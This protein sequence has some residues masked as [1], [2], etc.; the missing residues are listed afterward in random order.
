M[1]T[2]PNHQIVQTIY[3]SP[4]SVVYRGTR[5]EDNQ[6]VVIKVLKNEY[7]SPTD[8]VRYQQEYEITHHLD[9]PG[10]I[11][12]YCLEKYQNT[13]VLILEDFGGE[14][15]KQWMTLSPTELRGG[16][17]T[18]FRQGR[19]ADISAFLSLAIQMAE[20]IGEI[21]AAHLIHKDINPSNWVWNP[22]T[23][24]LKLID[25][26]ISTRLSRENPFLKNPERLEGTLAYMSPEQTGRMNRVLDY[27]TDFYSL[28]VSFYEMLTGGLPFSASDSL[29]LVHSHLAK[30]PQSIREI[31]PIVPPI[32]DELVIKLMA[33]NADDRYQS[34]FGLRNDL[35]NCLA[36]QELETLHFQLGD[37][38]FSGRFQLPQ[39]LYGR[40][41]EIEK[42]LAAFERSSEGATEMM[43]VAG[44]SG[45]GKSALVYEVHKPMTEKNGYFASGKFDQLQRNVPYSALSQAF[46]EFC[47]YL[48]SEPSTDRLNQ[49]R[50]TIL[51]AVGNNGQ[52][53]IDL[54]PALEL[55]IGPQP[56]VP[57]LG[58]TEAQNRF[59]WVF[60][61]FVRAISQKEHPLVIFIDDWQWADSASLT[62]LKVLMTHSDIHYFLLIGAYRDNEVDASHPLSMTLEDLGQQSTAV[63]NTLTLDNLSI[64]QVNALIADALHGPTT[65]VQPLTEL[66]YE[67]TFGNAFFTTEFLKALSD[68]GLLVFDFDSFRWQW[69]LDQIRQKEMTN[70]VVE[71]MVGKIQQ[72]PPTTQTVLKRAACIGNQFELA[73][74]SVIHKQSVQFTIDA[75]LEA[76]VEGLIIPLDDHYKIV[77]SQEQNDSSLSAG[78]SHFKFQHDRIQQAAY[79]LIPESEKPAL[80]LEI[81]RLLLA[82]RSEEHLDDKIFDIVNHL[83]GGQALMTDDAER[84][85]LASLNLRAGKKAKEGTAYQAALN[86]LALG[87]PLLGGTAWKKS[88]SLAFELHKEQGECEFLSGHFARSDQLLAIALDN[89]QSQ[90]DRTQV[91]VIK[92]ALLAGQGKYREAVAMAIEALNRFGLSVPSLE[93]TEAQQQATET[94]M[95]H[96]QELM[97][98]RAIDDLWHL[99]LMQDDEMKACTQIIAM[100]IDSIAI[101]GFSDLLAFYT[102]KMVNLSIQYGL[103][104]FTPVG[105]TFFATILSGGFKDYSRAY[106]FSALALRLNQEKLINQTVSSKIYNMYAFLSPLQEHFN[107]SAKYFRETYRIAIENGDFAYAGYAMAEIPRYILPIS[108]DEGTKTTQ[109]SIVYCQKSNN[110]PM[111]S[112]NQMYEGFINN[113]Q[114]NNSEQ[115]SF[116]HGHFTEEAFI[117]AFETTAPV[118]LAL[119]KRYK[120]QSLCLFGYYERALLLVH[121][122]ATWIAAFG[123][124]DLSLRSDYFLYAGITVAAL[125]RKASEE[126]EKQG[127]LEILDECIA[128]NQLLSEQCSINFEHAYLILEAEKAA[129][130]NRILDATHFYDQAIAVARQNDYRCNEGLASELA[131]QFWLT[132]QKEDF[133]AFYLKSAHYAYTLWGATGKIRDLEER[134]SMPNQSSGAAPKNA[135]ETVMTSSIRSSDGTS[136]FPTFNLDFA[137]V[138]KASQVIAGE[139]ELT[140]L[141]TRL[142]TIIIENAGAQR[143]VF[144]IQKNEQWFIEAEGV[145]EN[146]EVTVLQ[147]IPID[148]SEPAEKQPV[149]IGFLNYVIRTKESLV[150]Y[151]A[152]QEKMSSDPYLVGNHMKSA[153]C[154]PLINQGQLVGILYLENKLVEGVFTPARLEI[155]NVL[156]SQTAIS[157]ENALLYRTLEQKVE[158]RTAQLAEANQE[159]TALNEQLKSENL[160]MSAE[161]DVSRQ[162]QRML[163]PKEDELLQI[164]DLEIAGFMEPTDEVGGDYYDVLNYQGRILMGIGDVTGHGL[165]SGALAIMVQT[166]V[167]TLLANNETDPIKFLLTLN[168]AIYANSQRMESDKNMTLVLLDYKE[169]QLN[170]VGQHEEVIVVRKNSHQVELIETANLGFPIGLVE[171]LPIAQT[172]QLTL[173]SGDVV[174][175]YTD[176]ITEASNMDNVE[177]RLERLCDIAK[178][179]SHQS[180]PEICQAIIDDLQQFVGTKK[181]DDDVTLLVLK[182]K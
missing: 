76:V 118:F 56:E 60:Q 90:F 121:E 88:Y 174:V 105:Y 154:H 81:G 149:P 128:E 66:V 134:Y 46:N 96:Y 161:L 83:N 163:L 127:Y 28:G 142:M 157:L 164:D 120:L 144:L 98:N 79:A 82:S 150:L 42:L 23:N 40:E 146:K 165:E 71:L 35:E 103:S 78:Q 77:H 69:S 20:V 99:P 39:K 130:E 153:L 16:A 158:E 126:T 27:R 31:N 65:S 152:K 9:L 75:L 151:D 63:I 48:L 167:R 131:V 15:L 140:Q 53:L 94:E 173:N 50:K 13:R 123:G 138:V 73:T 26:S 145:I 49:W 32:V 54:I 115:T 159:I 22:L 47:H 68:E 143:G 89:A 87:L 86:Y 19:V 169:G 181:I 8:L 29:E 11:K 106:Q 4:H 129:L 41:P 59:H 62:L 179:N 80:H 6:P 10:V 95:A 171:E 117:E 17:K 25:F 107:T 45:V 21:H 51:A 34:A 177:Y 116:D 156:L 92:L 147:S 72:F 52:V 85:R 175:L 109:E 1:I 97:A 58:P 18:L 139:I 36:A 30:P 141:L 176:G 137:S 124:I 135:T 70:N 14:S 160:R 166:A 113:L 100:A 33:K 57:K 111:L 148:P 110:V 91:Y 12:A 178:L 43:W 37:K 44:Y 170:L 38:D 132:H 101:G 67:K 155:L 7:P 180:A 122:R 2:I 84:V 182:K 3:E 136:I 61:N 119:Y 172:S 24:Q 162:L 102:A 133:A 114:R 168:E 125:Y 5:I 104:A 108:L 74:L 112:V 93:Q 55:V 64:E